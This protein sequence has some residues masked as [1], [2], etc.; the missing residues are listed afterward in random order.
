M[1]DGPP[2]VQLYI[3]FLSLCSLLVVH[4]RPVLTVSV[5]VVG[6]SPGL[7]CVRVNQTKDHYFLRVP[8]HSLLQL[9]L[10]CSVAIL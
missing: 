5:A 4:Q 9:S 6:K 7:Q 10:C 1:T 2:C 8:P 3:S